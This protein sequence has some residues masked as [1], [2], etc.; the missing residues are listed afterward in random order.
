MLTSSQRKQRHYARKISQNKGLGYSDAAKPL[1]FAVGDEVIISRQSPYMPNRRA[2]V[3][4]ITPSADEN[5]KNTDM[6]RVR[7]VFHK[8]KS[9]IRA[10]FFADVITPIV[11]WE[12]NAL[13]QEQVVSRVERSRQCA[14]PGGELIT[15]DPRL[16]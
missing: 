15:L 11:A 14:T 16:Y 13:H 4:E 7:V 8:T 3:L 5:S 10:S 1:S 12:P 9:L 2:I 6:T